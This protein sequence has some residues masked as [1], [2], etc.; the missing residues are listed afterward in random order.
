VNRTIATLTAVVVLTLAACGSGTSDTTT[1][2]PTTTTTVDTRG[3]S[4]EAFRDLMTYC[5]AA[6]AFASC[7]FLI[8]STRDTD[9]C[10]VEATYRVVDHLDGIVDGDEQITALNGLMRN[11]LQPAGDCLEYYFGDE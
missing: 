3:W 5:Q 10:S 8:T 1:T 4:D 11:V 7:A 9:Q 6:G 2:I